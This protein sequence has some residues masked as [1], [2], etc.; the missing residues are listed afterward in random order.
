LVN[1]LGRS[2]SFEIGAGY[3]VAGY[4]LSSCVSV[5]LVRERGIMLQL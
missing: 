5:G 1:E 3:Y 2:N 4:R